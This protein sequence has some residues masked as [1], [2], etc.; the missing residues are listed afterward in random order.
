MCVIICKRVCLVVVLSV[1]ARMSSSQLPIHFG[2]S[3]VLSVQVLQYQL[4]LSIKD[5]PVPLP[6][7]KKPPVLL[8]KP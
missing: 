1:I 8:A 3:F 4:L 7:S 6:I 2:H 5:N